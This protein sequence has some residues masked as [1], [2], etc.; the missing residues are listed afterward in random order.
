MVSERLQESES[1]YQL[2]SFYNLV[3]AAAHHQWINESLY[4]S[5]LGV[6]SQF[7]LYELMLMGCLAVSLSNLYF[8][9]YKRDRSERKRKSLNLTSTE[10]PSWEMKKEHNLLYLN[11]NLYY[12][13]SGGSDCHLTEANFYLYLYRFIITVSN[14]RQVNAYC[15]YNSI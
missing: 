5:L 1:T 6:S 14:L 3:R 8:H 7:T 15:W 13:V 11:E 12:P 9:Y 2:L 4:S 10:T